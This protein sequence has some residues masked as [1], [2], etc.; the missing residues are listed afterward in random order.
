MRLAV[1]SD[2]HANAVAFRAVL[3]DVRRRGATEVW[4]LG[5]VV[6]DGPD[7]HATVKAVRRCCALVLAGNHDLVALHAWR[8]GAQIAG[9]D[10]T[11]SPKQ[12]GW[13]TDLRCREVR[14]GL[15]AVHGSPRSPA[16]GFISSHEAAHAS[17]RLAAGVTFFGHTH[18]PVAWLEHPN[19]RVVKRRGRPERPLELGGMRRCLLN[20]GSVGRPQA[21]NDRRASYLI[22]DAE[23]GTVTW[24]RVAYEGGAAP[25]RRSARAVSFA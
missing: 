25:R 11:L 1:T 23:Q 6:G 9:A 13:L 8:T 10:S 15:L 16:W 24:H 17:M 12:V 19:G 2:L 4:C 3:R 20:P 14:H 7:P 21:D 5:D 18:D 22:L